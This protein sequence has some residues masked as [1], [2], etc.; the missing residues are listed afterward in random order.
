MT[1][2]HYPKWNS[3]CHLDTPWLLTTAHDR[4]RIR[5]DQENEISYACPEKLCTSSFPSTCCTYWPYPRVLNVAHISVL[6]LAKLES[7]I[8][9]FLNPGEQPMMIIWFQSTSTNGSLA[10]LWVWFT[11]TLARDNLANAAHES[12]WVPRYELTECSL[13]QV[14]HLSV[15]DELSDPVYNFMLSLNVGP[16]P[17]FGSDLSTYTISLP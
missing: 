2:L 12:Y 9:V 15:F 5:M 11:I 17:E 14:R 6:G 1:R 3:G 4:D 10:R 8:M 13:T 7:I 16:T